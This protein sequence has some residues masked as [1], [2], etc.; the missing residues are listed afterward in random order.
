M[1]MCLSVRLCCV[2]VDIK[3]V[4]TSMTVNT[5]EA[6]K[7]VMGMFYQTTSDSNDDNC[8]LGD[9]DFERQFA[10]DSGRCTADRCRNVN[11]FVFFFA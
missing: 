7:M 8:P 1:L 9:V 10:I 5:K 6:Y 2:V 3:C 4:D 11:I